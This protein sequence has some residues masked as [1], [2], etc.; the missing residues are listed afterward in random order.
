MWCRVIDEDIS[1]CKEN[2]K[3]TNR[4]TNLKWIDV[5]AWVLII[6]KLYK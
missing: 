4:D 2:E 6:I 1:L 3:I 5:L